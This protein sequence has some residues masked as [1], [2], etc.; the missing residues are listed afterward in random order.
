L[1]TLFTISSS[2]QVELAFDGEQLSCSFILHWDLHIW[3]CFG[4]AF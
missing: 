2:I 4:L 1:N 3:S